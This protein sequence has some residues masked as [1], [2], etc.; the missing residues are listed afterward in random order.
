M[1]F[2]G[3]AN[4]PLAETIARVLH[5]PLGSMDVDQFSDGEIMVDKSRKF[6]YELGQWIDPEAFL[7]I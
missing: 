1:V 3:N 2:T 6:Q 4:R 5:L 7:E